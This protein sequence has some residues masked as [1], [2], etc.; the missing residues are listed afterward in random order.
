M[1]EHFDEQLEQEAAY[2][3]ALSFISAAEPQTEE[4]KEAAI[5][6]EIKRRET[7]SERLQLLITPE[8]KDN[9][10]REAKK[11]GTSVNQVINYILN[12]YFEKER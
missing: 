9:L 7:R 3:T 6:N 4:E 8:M 5:I 11:A 2:T 12:T 10:K 1:K